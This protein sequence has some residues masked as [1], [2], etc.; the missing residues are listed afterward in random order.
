MTAHLLRGPPLPLPERGTRTLPITTVR[1]LQKVYQEDQKSPLFVRILPSSLAYTLRSGTPPRR[2]VV[3]MDQSPQTDDDLLDVKA[4]AGILGVEPVTV[5]RWCR[6]GRLQCL[7]PGKAWRIRRTA[8]EAFLRHTERPQTLTGHLS[9]FLDIPDQVL[10]V[11]EDASLLLRLD[12]AFFQAGAAR[13]A[14]LV[15]LYEPQHRPRRTLAA[16]Y[17]QQGLETAWLEAT[18][19]LQW[20]PLAA[21]E[22]A[23][24]TLRQ[25]LAEQAGRES[26]IWVN[27]T[28]TSIALATA[29]QQQAELAELV[30]TS[31]LVV[32]TG[33]IE[34]A[35][36]EWPPA[37]TQWQLLG[38][39]R[40]VIRLTHAR[41]ML[42]RVVPA[43]T[44]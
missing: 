36:T 26:L 4:V 19:Q 43:P 40:G 25:L 9:A 44:R 12:A 21:P 42:S 30:A 20:C 7:K 5:Y 23:V 14:L 31:P 8:L 34:P 28:W 32:A 22:E 29:L 15:K 37:E 2:D 17:Q 38:S 10:A 16:A 6:H 11:V 35:V 18:G 27:I 33:V 41:L 1:L 39:L 3:L 13:G 24:P